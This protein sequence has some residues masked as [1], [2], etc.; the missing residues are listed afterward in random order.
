MTSPSQSV[1]SEPIVIT[2]FLVMVRVIVDDSSAQAA[3][4]NAVNVKSTEP[5]SISSEPG[6]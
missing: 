5:V 1:R 2:G 3:N 6:V 4:P